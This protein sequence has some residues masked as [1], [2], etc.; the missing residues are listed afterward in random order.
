MNIKNSKKADGHTY[1]GDI[2]GNLTAADL[3]D[4]VSSAIEENISVEDSKP[5]YYYNGGQKSF[6]IDVAITE[7]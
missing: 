2:I 1:Y 7:L 5:T 3:L 6:R 4:R